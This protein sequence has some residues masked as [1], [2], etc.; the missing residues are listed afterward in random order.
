MGYA[1]IVVQGRRFGG[2]VR[3][4]ALATLLLAGC[5]DV[6]GVKGYTTAPAEAGA[7][8][9]SS[10]SGIPYVSEACVKCIDDSCRMQQND[11]SNDPACKVLSRCL[12]ECKKDDVKCRVTCNLSTRRTTPMSKLMAC[13]AAQCSECAAAHATYGGVACQRDLEKEHGPELD[14]LSRSVAAL[15]LDSC[16]QDCP[17][18][19]RDLCECSDIYAPGS[20]SADASIGTPSGDVSDSDAGDARP[21]VEALENAVTTY[22]DDCLLRQDWSCLGSVPNLDVPT[23]PTELTLHVG[24]VDVTKT[25]TFTLLTNVLVR[26]CGGVE[27]GCSKPAPDAGLPTDS[28]GFVEFSLPRESGSS[29]GWFFDGLTARWDF[30]ADEPSYFLLYF[31][32]L[33]LSRTPRWIVR[34]LVSKQ[35][36]TDSVKI[37]LSEDADWPNKGG[38]VWSVTT[39]NGLA[40]IGVQASLTPVGH[41]SLDSNNSNAYYTNGSWGLQPDQNSTS[42]SGLGAFVNVSPGEWDLNLNLSA[43]AGAHLDPDS[44]P[45]HSPD[46]RRIGTY[47]LYVRPGAITTVALAPYTTQ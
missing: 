45:T 38:I 6:L 10:V 18:P 30:V 31:Y 4:M 16:R 28:D 19:L 5:R 34:R 7:R 14:R 1:G 22:N 8:Y 27:V 40:G 33:Y 23:L 2:L 41:V 12:A 11:C 13:A 32:P 15:E 3:P 43:D 44:R 26:H 21:V 29:S 20:S 9:T 35:A 39:C 36:A 37:A 46:E 47:R 25:T 42:E 24:F 17:P